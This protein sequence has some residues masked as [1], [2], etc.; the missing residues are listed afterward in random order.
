[1]YTGDRLPRPNQNVKKH[2]TYFKLSIQDKATVP[3]LL[4][5]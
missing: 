4:S 5:Y 1:M 2:S 3:N